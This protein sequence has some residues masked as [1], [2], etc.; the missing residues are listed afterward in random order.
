M[1]D[2]TIYLEALRADDNQS[3]QQYTSEPSDEELLD[4]LA[5]IRGSN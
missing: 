1:I 5:V 4:L 2:D 3:Q